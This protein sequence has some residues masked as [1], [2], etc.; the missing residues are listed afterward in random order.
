MQIRLK[1]LFLL[2]FS[3]LLSFS[4]YGEWTEFLT[5]KDEILYIDLEN[6]Q[7][8]SDGYVYYWMML[9]DSSKSQKVYVQTDCGFESINVLQIDTHTKKMGGG[10]VSVSHPEQGWIYAAPD[11]SNYRV[12]K[13]ICE[14]VDETLE[15]RVNS[16]NNFKMSLEYKNKIN[17]LYEKGME[18]DDDFPTVIS[19][20]ENLN[21]YISPM[22][23]SIPKAISYDE[24][25]I[26]ASDRMMN[27]PEMK[28]WINADKKIDYEQVLEVVTPLKKFNNPIGFLTE[29]EF[30]NGLT[31]GEWVRTVAEKV[32]SNWRYQG[33]EDDWN[34][35]VYV[36][37][38]RDGTIVA[39][40]V[41]NSNI[42]DS[43]KAKVFQD[44]IRRAVYKSSPLPRMD[45]AYYSNEF[46]FIF[47]VN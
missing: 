35:E 30:V 3:L 40:D 29:A 19:I 17:N 26:I 31:Q 36:V 15:Q 4:S 11:T 18:L 37:Q 1:K 8:R 14:M 42:G 25:V 22:D 44:S 43:Q 47:S 38:D 20:D 5:D 6:F 28:V 21:Y 32:K 46:I 7:E 24:L 23:E 27:N 16:V 34:A 41:R 10:S 9:S 2:L 12:L 33:A 13:A 39:V 45:D